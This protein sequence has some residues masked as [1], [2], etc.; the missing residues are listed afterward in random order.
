MWDICRLSLLLNGML[1]REF[2]GKNA[3]CDASYHCYTKIW[4][5]GGIIKDRDIDI[6]LFDPNFGIVTIYGIGVL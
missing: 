5:M 4:V 3:V 1:R 6:N 2:R